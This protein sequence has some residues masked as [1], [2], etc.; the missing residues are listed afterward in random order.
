MRKDQKGMVT[1]IMRRRDLI[2]TSQLG[3]V[4]KF[5]WFVSALSK[6]LLFSFVVASQ[7]QQQQQHVYTD[8]FPTHDEYDM[9]ALDPET[10]YGSPYG[11]FSR[12]TASRLASLPLKLPEVG[13][14][15]LEFEPTFT[16]LHDFYGRPFVCRVYHED[17]LD[18]ADLKESMFNTPILK[19]GGKDEEYSPV[20]NTGKHTDKVDPQNLPNSSE[21]EP[22]SS[23]NEHSNEVEGAANSQESSIDDDSTMKHGATRED[24]DAVQQK[25]KSL[26]FAKMDRIMF[27]KEIQQR[28]SRLSG[29]CAQIHPDW[30]SYE[31]CYDKKVTQFHINVDSVQVGK[32][33]D[34]QLEDVTSLG[35]FSERKIISFLDENDRLNLDPNAIEGLDFSEGRVE[36][37]RVKDTFIN[38]DVCP[39]TGKPRVTESTLRCCSERVLSKSKGG[40]LKNGRPVSTDVL[41]IVQ[42]TEW[43]EAVCHYNITLCTPLLCDDT[44]APNESTK[45]NQEKRRSTKKG[46][47]NLELDTEI[48][49]KMSIPE[50]LR[51]TFGEPGDFCI[52]TATGGWWVYEFCPGEYIRQFHETTLMDRLSGQPS[53]SVDIEHIL[54]R[55]IS[56]DHDW[57]TK[58]NEWVNVVNATGIGF[59]SKTKASPTKNGRANK[60]PTQLGGNGAFFFQEYTKGDVCDHEDVTDSAIKAGS[61]GEGGIERA[62]TIKYS[63]G[64]V[65]DMNVKEDSTCHYIVD[66][67]VP[68]LCAHPLFK[69]P[70]SKKRVVKCL[71]LPEPR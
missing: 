12:A 2:S 23:G 22:G 45:T 26:S 1:T 34:I 21:E 27:V 68:T 64:T 57:V 39:D 60:L 8:S 7:Q 44:V 24:S 38:G 66:I 36:L 19:Q 58:E 15:I 43:S 48:V 25:D 71:P 10:P 47:V 35:S 31:W 40:L 55:Y 5:L 28:L 52:Q 65:L 51:N 67:S 14:E 42:T 50:V 32:T 46:G 61:F 16:T 18:P 33:F 56:E 70:T 6:L 3:S 54:G 17:E 20:D 29:L 13:E 9:M 37:A 30:W 69:A 62:S 4:I 53:T 49:G 63:C 59:G 41:T 11:G